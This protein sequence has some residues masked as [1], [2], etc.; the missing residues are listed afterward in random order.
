MSN[1]FGN[2]IFRTFLQIC[3]VGIAATGEILLNFFLFF[4]PRSFETVSV[5]Y[6]KFSISRTCENEWFSI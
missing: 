1:Y 6:I 2:A 5:F 4:F 3:K